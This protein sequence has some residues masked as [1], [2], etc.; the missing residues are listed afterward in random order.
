M[1]ETI[2]D[3][4]GPVPGRTTPLDEDALDELLDGQDALLGDRL[5]QRLDP[6]DQLHQRAAADVDRAL[7][8]RT[9]LG[10]TV[11]LLGVGW[12]TLRSLLTDGPDAADR[13]DE[14]T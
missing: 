1:D 9:T 11:E 5:R 13:R 12:W 10:A 3:S 2:H 8:S 4:D 7:R 14:E 6:G